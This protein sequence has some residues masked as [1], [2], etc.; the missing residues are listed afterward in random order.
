MLPLRRKVVHLA[1]DKVQHDMLSE[2]TIDRLIS[3][4]LWIQ[5]KQFFYHVIVCRWISLGTNTL[6]WFSSVHYCTNLKSRRRQSSII[7]ILILILTVIL[8]AFIVTIWSNEIFTLSTNLFFSFF[9]RQF[10]PTTFIANRKQ[11][12]YW[13]HYHIDYCIMLVANFWWLLIN[14]VVLYLLFFSCFQYISSCK[15]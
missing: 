1:L 11:L 15:A 12:Y 10:W 7:L 14:H 9:K 8:F 3:F 6:L 2:E 5:K 4:I 13:H